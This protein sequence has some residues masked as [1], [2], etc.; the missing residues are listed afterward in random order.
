MTYLKSWKGFLTETKRETRKKEKIKKRLSEITQRSASEVL[1]WFDGDY[2]KLSFDELFNGNLRVAFPLATEDEA[3]LVRIIELLVAENFGPAAQNVSFPTKTVTQKIRRP[4]GEEVIEEREVA[5]LKVSRE[6]SKVIPA[7][8]RKGEKVNQKETL[9]IAKALKKVKAPDEIQKWWLNKQAEYT[10]DKNWKQIEDVYMRHRASIRTGKEVSA[11]GHVVIVSR[12]P[13]DVLRM[14]DHKNIRSCHSEGNGYFQC[15]VAESKGHGP[16]AYLVKGEDFHNFLNP[17]GDWGIDYD[18]AA[19]EDAPEPHSLSEFDKLEIFV[20]RDRGVKGIV[21]QS[22]LRLRKFYDDVNGVEFTAPEFRTYGP[23]PPG[24]RDV[25]TKWA[26]NEQK[27]NFIN[28]DGELDLPSDYDLTIFGG[29]YRDTSDGELLNA[30]FSES[31]Q[32]INEYRG[33]VSQDAE[34]ENAGRFDQWAEEVEEHA[35]RANNILEHV[36]FWADIE[37][38]G[39]DQIYVLANASME[40]EI[41]LAGWDGAEDIGLDIVPQKEDKNGELNTHPNLRRIPHPHSGW[42]N[43]QDFERKLSQ[44]E[45]EELE[46]DLELNPPRLSI[47]YSF[48]CEECTNPDDVGEWLDYVKTGY[49]DAY[50]NIAEMVRQELVDGGYVEAGEWDT[51]AEDLEERKFENFQF[52]GDTDR[53]GAVWLYSKGGTD[54]AGTMWPLD[55]HLPKEFMASI[56]GNR[57]HYSGISIKKAFESIIDKKQTGLGFVSYLTEPAEEKIAKQLIKLELV[58]GAAAREQLHFDLGDGWEPRIF[59]ADDLS[60][61]LELGIGTYGL[62]GQIGAYLRAILKSNDTKKEIQTSIKFVELL[63]KNL[64]SI[65]KAFENVLRPI[66]DEKWAELKKEKEDLLSGKLAEPIL[67]HLIASKRSDWERLALWIQQNWKDFDEREKRVAMDSYLSRFKDGWDYVH[68]DHLS[69][70]GP[71]YWDGS[72]QRAGGGMSYR[73]KGLSMHDVM[74]Y[75]DPNAPPGKDPNYGKDGKMVTESRKSKTKRR[76]RI[77]FL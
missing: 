73:W 25:V 19:G 39:D 53:E 74:P 51:A 67:K 17:V 36:G 64:G 11:T 33:D 2:S 52:I 61:T 56:P 16:I 1:D 46:W 58:A 31:G 77:K 24:F 55:L 65:T 48:R 70:K 9:N 20:D 14:S 44:G 62:E 7:G 5:D 76:L 6:V 57:A 63:D 30:F 69:E 23:H 49:D 12:H 54:G 28:D 75:T 40:I 4:G 50:N 60:K 68:R 71:R 72:V 32:D 26:W 22:R 47:R 37:E 38:G 34:D 42:S 45:E 18:A 27:E 29:S 66:L 41:P 10:K 3:N 8:P 15:A 21:A 13:L 35:A 59:S 43:L